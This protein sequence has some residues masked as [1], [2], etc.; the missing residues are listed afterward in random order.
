MEYKRAKV[1]HDAFL[2]FGSFY[3]CKIALKKGDIWDLI[4]D[5]CNFCVLERFHITI[6]LATNDF[7]E[8]FEKMDN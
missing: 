5:G 2:Y 6:E 3:K 1:T 4:H 7:N 8:H